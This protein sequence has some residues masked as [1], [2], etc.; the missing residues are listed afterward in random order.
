MSAE[1]NIIQEGQPI[2]KI[3]HFF[4][5]IGVG[6]VKLSAG[7]EVGDTI[8]ILGGEVDFEQKIDSIEVDHKK[9][10]SAKKGDDIGIKLGQK[11][12][13]GYKVYKL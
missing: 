6:I 8:R 3:T 13:E 11:V 9:V 12:R 7:L 5:K 1:K 4:N 10:K 2:G